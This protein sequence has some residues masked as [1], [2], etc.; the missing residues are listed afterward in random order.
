MFEPPGFALIDMAP[1]EPTKARVP[2]VQCSSD[3]AWSF[4]NLMECPIIQFS[5]EEGCPFDDNIAFVR[6]LFRDMLRRGSHTVQRP[7]MSTES[8]YM[9]FALFVSDSATEVNHIQ[10]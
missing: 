2:H 8:L 10:E 7:G 4:G 6:R 9:D 1:G 5:E 3:E